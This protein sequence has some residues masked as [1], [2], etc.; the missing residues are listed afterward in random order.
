MRAFAWNATNVS[1]RL[2]SSL[3][4]FLTA[5]P[6]RVHLVYLEVAAGEQERRNRARHS[7]VPRAASAKC[8]LRWRSATSSP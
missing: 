3:I 2:R 1:R 8:W 5:Y 4:E 7:P 6:V